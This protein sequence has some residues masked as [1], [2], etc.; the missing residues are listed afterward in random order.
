MCGKKCQIKN[1]RNAAG[2]Q[3]STGWKWS[4]G[5]DHCRKEGLI[6]DRGNKLKQVRKFKRKK[7]PF[8]ILSPWSQCV[9]IQM[10]K[11]SDVHGNVS[12]NSPNNIKFV[13]SNRKV[14]RMLFP[15]WMQYYL[16]YIRPAA[17]ALKKSSRCW[18]CVLKS[19]F[20]FTHCTKWTSPLLILN[21]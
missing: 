3:T 9:R 21:A 14:R 4:D 11:S 6:F 10:V 15:L 19:Y 16:D 20:N 17:A 13:A 1:V 5:W 12:E 18:I 8:H 2:V 7:K